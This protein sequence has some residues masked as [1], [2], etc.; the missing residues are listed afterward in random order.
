MAK[1]FY[2]RIKHSVNYLIKKKSGEESFFL[3]KGNTEKSSSKNDAWTCR[4]WI[5]WA[6]RNSL[7]ILLIVK[8]NWSNVGILTLFSSCICWST[9]LWLQDLSVPVY[10][11]KKTIEHRI[12]LISLTKECEFT[13]EVLQ[14]DFPKVGLKQGNEIVFIPSDIRKEAWNFHERWRGW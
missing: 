8:N 4:Y 14:G 7:Q 12:Q 6:S 11:S 3:R 2:V 9:S 10:D 1:S 5:C 13:L